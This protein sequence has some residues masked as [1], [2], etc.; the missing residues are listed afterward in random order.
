MAAPGDAGRCFGS[1]YLEGVPILDDPFEFLALLQLQGGGQ[2]SR[3]DEIILAILITS[4][5]HLQFREVTHAEIL[6]SS[7]VMCKPYFFTPS[8]AGRGNGVE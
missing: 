6:A 2:R 5:N 3:T 1:P 7:L 8:Q 4:L